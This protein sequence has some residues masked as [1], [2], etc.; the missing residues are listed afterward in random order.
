VLL[1]SLSN[2]LPS[3]AF[4]DF[5]LCGLTYLV[6]LSSREFKK[7]FELSSGHDIAIYNLTRFLIIHGGAKKKA[8][9]AL[10]VDFSEIEKVDQFNTRL[11]EDSRL[12]LN[13][14]KMNR[15][16]YK[17]FKIPQELIETFKEKFATVG[18]VG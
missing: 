16:Y 6:N 10:C 8:L 4:Q 18:A 5:F 15:L 12:P 13:E 2:R 9:Q 11:A 1:A 17:E 14:D 3:G 7:L